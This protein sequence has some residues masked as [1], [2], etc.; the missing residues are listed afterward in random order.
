MAWDGI[1]RRRGMD[2]E[3]KTELAV[4]VSKVSEWMS[5]TKD[6]RE[7]LCK[8]IDRIDIQLSNHITE[9]TAAFVSLDK[10]T[11]SMI[12]T[13]NEKILKLPCEARKSWLWQIKIL[14]AFVVAMILGIFYDW[15][16]KK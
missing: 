9:I 13:V 5:S 1:E 15:V 3:L 11:N 10:T 16:R 6:Y 12:S 2:S 14:W 4:F 7:Q 8:K